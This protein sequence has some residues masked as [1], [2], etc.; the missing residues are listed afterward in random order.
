MW[1]V[2]DRSIPGVAE[3][4]RVGV[5][6][7]HVAQEQDEVVGGGEGPGDAADPAQQPGGEVVGDA[8]Q[9][10][11]GFLVGLGWCAAD[12]QLGGHGAEPSRRHAERSPDEFG[13]GLVHGLCGE[14]FG[15]VAEDER[16]AV[17]VVDGLAWG[18]VQVLLQDAAP[19][20]VRVGAV[21]GF[22]IRA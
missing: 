16:G 4:R 9:G 12:G 19:D 18:A 5:G 14:V 2:R 15:E 22:E 1:T 20:R 7:E 10:D 8:T 13:G 6:V 21:E 3:R 17:G 11:P